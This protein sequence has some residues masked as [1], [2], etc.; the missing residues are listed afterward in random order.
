MLSVMSYDVIV[1]GARCGGAA[2]ALLLARRGYRVLLVDADKVP[3]DMPMST[4]LIWPSGVRRLRDWGLLDQ[5]IESQCPPVRTC[6]LDLGALRLVGDPVPAGDVWDSYAPRRFVLDRILLKAAVD[7]GVELRPDFRVDQLIWDGGTVRGVRQGSA[8]NTISEHASVVVGADG[9]NSRVVQLVQSKTYDEVPPRQGTYFA[10]WRGLPLRR[11]E[12]FVRPGR[13]VY[14]FP[15]NDDLT[16]VGVNW[17]IADFAPVKAAVEQNY[18]AVIAAC[19]PELHARLIASSRESGFVGG[20]IANVMRKPHG[21]GWALVGDAGLTVDPCTAAGISNAFRDAGF[22]AE[23]IDQGLS[24]VMPMQEALAAYHAR[25]DAVAKPIYDFTCDLAAFTPPT[26]EMAALFAALADNPA[27]TSRFFG[28]LAQTVSP[29][30]FFAS[31]NVGR[32]MGGAHL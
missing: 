28:M 23:A 2:S 4:H 32:I 29:A 1:V 13:G 10:Y 12:L 18:L 31:E 17:A 5:V 11:I 9:R 20:A 24:G 22:L 30:E 3:G 16:L 7:A 15:T 19:A 21:P 26:T 6:L 14:L 8:S 27:Q 25:R